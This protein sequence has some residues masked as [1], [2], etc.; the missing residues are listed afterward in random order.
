MAIVFSE[1]DVN[2]TGRAS[3]GVI[4]VRFKQGSQDEV[5]GADVL[6][7]TDE[8]LTLSSDAYAKRNKATA[9]TVQQR[10]GQGARNFKKGSTVVGLLTVKGNEEMLVITE[11]GIVIRVPVDSISLKKGKNTIGV[12]VQRLD[13][14]DRIASVALAPMEETEE[15]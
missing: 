12:K 10:G 3:L 8:V 5:V 14:T 9:Y 13:E 2:P 11:S 15:D 1:A 4:G 7:S 6:T